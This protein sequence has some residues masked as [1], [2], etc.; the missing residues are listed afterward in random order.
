VTTTTFQTYDDIEAYVPPADGPEVLLVDLDG[1][2]CLMGDRGPYD[3]ARVGD[4][5]PNV[6]VRRLVYAF[7]AAAVRVVFMSGRSE[8]CRAATEAWLDMHYALKYEALFMRA[9]GD[10]R[11]DWVVK[12]ELFD[13]HIRD[14]YRVVAVADD[15]NQVVAMWRSIGLTVFQVADGNF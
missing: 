5:L 11:K 14:R 4:D 2:M 13:Q 15:R 8:K 7:A 6:P 9:A 12:A 10:V 1:T 3:E